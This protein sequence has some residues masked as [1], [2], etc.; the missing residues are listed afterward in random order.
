ML[1]EA[2][3]EEGEEEAVQRVQAEGELTPARG[4]EELVDKVER[5]VGET[6]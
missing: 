3:R 4:G 2:F 6:A 5:E 1:V